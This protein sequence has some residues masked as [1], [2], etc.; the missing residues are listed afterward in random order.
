MD[1]W[2]LRFVYKEER[3]KSIPGADERSYTYFPSLHVTFFVMLGIPGISSFH[4]KETYRRGRE[5]ALNS[6]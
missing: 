4:M 6:A 3:G 2:M 5:V 1:G